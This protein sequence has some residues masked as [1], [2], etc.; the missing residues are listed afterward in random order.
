M[1][2]LLWMLRFLIKLRLSLWLLRQWPSDQARKQLAA[3]L[4]RRYPTKGY[5]DKTK[6]PPGFPTVGYPLLTGASL[7]MPLRDLSSVSA[8]CSRSFKPQTCSHLFLQAE[9]DIH[10]TALNDMDVKDAEP[11]PLPGNPILL[12]YFSYLHIVMPVE[13]V[14][15]K[16][17]LAPSRSESPEL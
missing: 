6:C 15:D 5:S 2:C 8:G 10:S 16:P 9:R 4:C 1:R 7:W 14:P 12:W 11:V 13:F 17:P 3:R